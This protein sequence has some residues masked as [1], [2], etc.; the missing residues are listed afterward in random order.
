[1]QIKSE[2]KKKQK[3]KPLEA[4]IYAWLQGLKKRVYI[5]TSVTHKNAYKN[6]GFQDEMEQL[7]R[8]ERVAIHASNIANMVIFVAKVY[9]A[10]ESKSLAVIA[11][12]LDSLLDLLSGFILWFTASAMRKPNPHLYPIGKDR[13]QPVVRLPNCIFFK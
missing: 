3:K 13:M 6:V 5:L 12:T 7:A 8:S 9:A 2:N 10:V 11:S 4:I 1:M